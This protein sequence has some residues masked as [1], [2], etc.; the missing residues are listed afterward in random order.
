MF[1][2]ILYYVLNKNC[3]QIAKEIKNNNK[4]ICSNFINVQNLQKNNYTE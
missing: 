2:N 1:K 3:N 4:D